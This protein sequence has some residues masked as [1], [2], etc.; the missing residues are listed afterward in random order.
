MVSELNP[1]ARAAS[2]KLRN[3]SVAVA[4]ALLAACGAAE[5]NSEISSGSGV[6]DGHGTV[7][8]DG[9]TYELNHVICREGRWDVSSI[10]SF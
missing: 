2:T 8:F 9:I 6:Q 1:L 7:E 10:T 5:N 4:A 3:F